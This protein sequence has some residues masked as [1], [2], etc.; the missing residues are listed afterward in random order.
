MV[1]ELLGAGVPPT[2]L[3]SLGELLLTEAVL[4]RSVAVCGH[5]LDYG[6]PLGQLCLRNPVDVAM[7]LGDLDVLERLL[8]HP[9][10]SATPWRSA[11]TS[12]VRGT[13]GRSASQSEPNPAMF[14]PFSANMSEFDRV[15]A[16]WSQFGRLD[17]E[18]TE[19]AQIRAMSS[20]ASTKFGM[21]STN[22]DR[23]VFGKIRSMFNQ[24]GG[25][26]SRFRPPLADFDR[27]RPVSTPVSATSASVGQSWQ[28]SANSDRC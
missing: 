16:I 13:W 10:V 20:P 21:I 14:G 6:C 28:T 5:L 24:I 8:T 25:V 9:L 26:G 27:L 7:R 22:L 19:F 17:V 18:M 12:W 23:F 2:G 4:R 15:W 3:S 11:A 1:L